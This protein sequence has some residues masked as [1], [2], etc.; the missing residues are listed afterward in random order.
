[1]PICMHVIRKLIDIYTS[2]SIVTQYFLRFSRNLTFLT[3]FIWITGN[4]HNKAITSNLMPS[5][6]ATF[7]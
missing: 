3:S 4:F 5:S 2:A 7:K 6:V 1:M